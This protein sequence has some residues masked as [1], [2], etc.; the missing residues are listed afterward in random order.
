MSPAAH[1]TASLSPPPPL[2]PVANPTASGWPSAPTESASRR[3]V[4]APRTRRCKAHSPPPPQQFT[5]GARNISKQKVTPV[6]E[7]K[8][9]LQLVL[10]DTGA[11]SPKFIFTG[12]S[13]EANKDRTKE[14]VM[15]IMQAAKL[16]PT[17]GSS[18]GGSG[19]SGAASAGAAGNGGVS[20][21]NAMT[22]AV[23]RGATSDLS[24][25]DLKV[26][27]FSNNPSIHEVCARHR[28]CPHH[29]HYPHSVS[30]VTQS[31]VF[32]CRAG[33]KWFWWTRR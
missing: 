16:P 25:K 28:F 9:K 4:H 24:D 33:T 7:P 12:P 14:A 32:I 3:L 5:I 15:N 22:Q 17:A 1:C 30:Y 6:G 10:S 20:E 13:A 11:K 31:P 8:P 29:R 2:S 26:Q 19:G 18:G 21:A 27:V 23:L